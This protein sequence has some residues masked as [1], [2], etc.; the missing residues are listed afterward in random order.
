MLP[1]IPLIPLLPL[2]GFLF[3]GLAG[4]KAPSRVVSVVACGTVIL[5][6]I[7]SAG[8][9]WELSRGAAAIEE[10]RGRPGVTVGESRFQ[11]DVWTWVPL[12]S[13]APQRAASP[14]FAA[15]NEG[16]ASP[17]DERTGA[18]SVSVPMSFALDRLSAVMV[19]IVT[20]VGLIIHLYSVGYMA[21]DP[22][23]GRYFSYLNLFMAMMLILVLGG[24]FLVMFVGWEG[25]G[26]CSYLLIG[27]WYEDPEKAYAGRKAFI[28]NRIGD[29]AFIVAMLWILSI[30]GTLDIRAVMAGTAA[31]LAGPVG[32]AA[33]TLIALGLFIGACGKSAQIPLY[34]W[35]PDAMAGPT[36]VSALIHAATMV[37]AGVYMVSRC[38]TLFLHAPVAMGTVAVVGAATALLAATIGLAQNDIKKVL[39]YSTVSQL[40]LMFLGAGVGAFA[41]SIFHLMTHA[42][43][44]ALLFLGSGSVI[45][46][47]SGEQDLR[48]MGGLKSRLP[49]TYWTF[50]IG[51]VAIAGIPPL[52]GFFSKDEILAAA[53][54]A[55]R[56]LLWLTGTAVS[57]CTAFYMFRLVRLAFHGGF[58]GTPAQERHIHES[59]RSMTGPL[60]ILALL[61]IAGGW[62][63][64]P[65][66]LG[67]PAGIPNLIERWLAPAFA[68]AGAH[69]EAPAHAGTVGV[70]MLVAIGV[71]VAG[72]ALALS[73]YRPGSEAPS[74]VARALGPLYRLVAGRYHVDELY[75]A[76]VL[77]AYYSGC[78]AFDAFDR[79]AVDG[80]VNATGA[81]AQAAGQVVRLFQ[82]GLVRN[83][84]LLFLLAT[85]ALLWWFLR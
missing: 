79:V 66:V 4:K 84:A 65:A 80:T 34:V 67:Q 44:K 46:A 24:N 82:T 7:V 26:L 31:G 56:P 72:I 25:V 74:R 41:A 70:L 52:A 23:T 78:D 35:L 14:T 13:M 45:H 29:A 37:T 61:S 64:I 81:V 36:P 55:G 49:V 43:F 19:L 48:R 20:G 12:G 17:G 57:L 73:F 77:R 2:I 50:V 71:G 53:W 38:S 42:F 6:F 11:V 54:G 10:Y 3:C 28:V 59:P 69:A 22:G 60:V 63:G 39:A 58:R 5:S 9:V 83:Y 16:S 33:V 40:G 51:A 15:T 18:L 68:P 1:F 75:D 8:A 76:T 21:G 30:F 27:F 85:S 32:G 47:M 62:I